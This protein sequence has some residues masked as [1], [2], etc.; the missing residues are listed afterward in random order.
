MKK[1]NYWIRYIN[2]SKQFKEE[3]KLLLPKIEKVLSSG[4]YILS[5]EV[6]KF[7]SEFIK[8]VN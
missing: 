7:S 8:Y 6:E 3:K 5:D 1:N 4:K 2:L